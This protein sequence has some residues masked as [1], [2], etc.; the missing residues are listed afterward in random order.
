MISMAD[1]TKKF[2]VRV[3]ALI[4]HIPE[5]PKG[6]VIQYQL[7]EAASSVAA[8]Y[9]AAQ[10]SRSRAEFISKLSIAFEETDESRLWIELLVDAGMIPQRLVSDLLK[11]GDELCAILASSRNTARR[12]AGSVKQPTKSLDFKKAPPADK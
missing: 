2:A 8:N 9:R 4:D 7:A 11:E 1:R 10:R 6:R 5:S 12:N 3:F